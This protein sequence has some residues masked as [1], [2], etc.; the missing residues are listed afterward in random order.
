[1]KALRVFKIVGIALIS[2]GIISCVGFLVLAQ[3]AFGPPREITNVSRYSEIRN[4]WPPSLV[5]HFP[6]T[7]PANATNVQ[8]AYLPS[9]LQ[10]GSHFQLRLKLPPDKIN[11]LL[12]HFSATAK[13]R[14]EGGDTNDHINQ[15]GG[16]PTTRFYTSGSS[17][18]S[19]PATYEILVIDAQP[20]GNP[21]FKWNHGYSY[22][23]A[24]DNSASEIVYWVEEW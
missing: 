19:F 1:M 6:D 9:F 16:V 22:G 17:D 5:Q 14:Y 11:D 7:I 3:I 8:L 4:Q 24:I 18:H 20:Q 13:R 23:V 15:S 2:L 10:G 12:V 21:E